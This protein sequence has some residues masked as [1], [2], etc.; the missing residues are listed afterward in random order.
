MPR[1]P[2]ELQRIHEE[3]LDAERTRLLNKLH[4]GYS[5]KS[6][7]EAM[8]LRIRVIERELGIEGIPYNSSA[9][10]GQG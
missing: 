2:S 4:T 7:K 5:P 6:D 9:F 1:N 3:G 10:G 8:L